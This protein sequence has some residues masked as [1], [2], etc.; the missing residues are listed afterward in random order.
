MQKVKIIK[1]SIIFDLIPFLLI[2]FSPGSFDKVDIINQSTENYNVKVND[3]LAGNLNLA[4]GSFLKWHFF[5]MEHKV[6]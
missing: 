4:I 6:F 5:I 1:F 3:Q 2:I